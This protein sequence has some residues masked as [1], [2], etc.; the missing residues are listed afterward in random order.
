MKLPKVVKIK[1]R[2][3]FRIHRYLG[4]GLGKFFVFDNDGHI[5]VSTLQP[6]YYSYA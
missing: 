6:T 1:K 3:L 4:D 5:G 2:S